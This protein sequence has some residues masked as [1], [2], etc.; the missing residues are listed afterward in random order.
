MRKG[1]GGFATAQWQRSETIRFLRKNELPL[2]I[3]SNVPDAIYMLAG[4]RASLTPRE[5][6]LSSD[7]EP[8][9]DEV[10]T[11]VADASR[12]GG[13]TVVW[14][15]SYW[16]TNVYDLGDLQRFV[17]LEPVASFPDAVVY[18][19]TA[20]DAGPSGQGASPG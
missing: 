18:R 20:L 4:R 3:Y 2:P 8:N 19:A 5:T 13:A 11:F 6:L 16:R 10:R 14:F 15:H 12:P 1:V 9:R 7:V 17:H